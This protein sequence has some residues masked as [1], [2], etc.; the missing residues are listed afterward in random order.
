MNI[1]QLIYYNISF[2]SAI[3]VLL[4]YYIDKTDL[5]KYFISLY[6]IL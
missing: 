6:N 5:I 3:Y 2:T 4:L 1:E